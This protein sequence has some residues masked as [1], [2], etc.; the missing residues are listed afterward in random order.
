MGLREFK[1]YIRGYY[2]KPKMAIEHLTIGSKNPP[3]VKGKL[4]L[5]S[6]RF[7]PYAQRAHLVLNAKN[8]PH[9]VV[10]INLAVKPEWYGDMI[11][12]AKVPALVVDGTDLYESLIIADYLDEEYPT[13]PLHSNKPLQ[14]AQ[15]RILIESFNKVT[16]AVYSLYS[17]KSIDKGTFEDFL[18]TIDPFEKE[19]MTRGDYFGGK[20]IGMVDFM[21]WPWFERFPLLAILIGPE[22]KLPESRF[23]NLLKWGKRMLEDKAVKLSYL[24]PEQHAYHFKMRKAGTPDYT[25]I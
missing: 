1:Y 25:I 22:F 21:I 18:C 5:Y 2:S 15:D 16:I 20:S 23:S 13:V 3:L 24:T 11:P 8:I 14:K 19:L 10:Y 17:A 7:C 9:D 12:T 6:M 4:R